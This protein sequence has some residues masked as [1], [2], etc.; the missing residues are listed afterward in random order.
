MSRSLAE[1]YADYAGK[2]ERSSPVEGIITDETAELATVIK[3]ICDG[4]EVPPED[5]RIYPIYG[6]DLL[7]PKE[8]RFKKQ[9][10][11]R[12][13][14]PSAY[15]PI[16]YPK[17]PE[18]GS[19]DH[20]YLYRLRSF[21]HTSVSVF[22]RLEIGLAE[23]ELRTPNKPIQFWYWNGSYD[24]NMLS[25]KSAAFLRKQ[26]VYKFAR[27][28]KSFQREER[29]T[30]KPPILAPGV[31]AQ[32]YKNSIGFLCQNKEEYD[33]YNIAYKRGIL[34]SGD[35]GC[36]KTYTCKWLRQLCKK[37]NLVSRIISMQQYCQ[38]LNRGNVN[39][40]FRIAHNRPGVIIFDDM[41]L[42][43]KDRETTNNP[44]DLSIFLSELDGLTPVRGV[45]FV[46]TT[47]YIKELDNAAI[48]PGRIDLWLRFTPPA[49]NLRKQYI[50]T[51]FPEELLKE[52]DV[53]AITDRTNEYNFAEIEEIRKLYCLDIIN[54][55]GI[56]TER[57]F[58]LFE[59]HRK[60]FLEQIQM[61]YRQA[62]DDETYAVYEE[63]DD[64]DILRHLR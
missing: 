11:L 23:M 16:R 50:E 8:V 37:K 26:D 28:L 14:I 44:M 12:W 36:G 18:A 29:V 39:Q 6:S 54:S 25:L 9:I 20:L 32:I 30:I 64:M 53:E 34:L 40:L 47:N 27:T 60:E 31:L 33:R 46:F 59:K 58:T 5:L 21:D 2:G 3:T 43:I 51:H 45:V 4:Y 19:Y 48:R 38:A 61:G 52:I 63:E 13:P 62:A 24:F 22:D 17:S 41:H 49:E 7:H 10:P 56:D 55:K 35:P 57:V 15:A 42:M 1:I